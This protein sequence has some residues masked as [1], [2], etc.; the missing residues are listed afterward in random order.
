VSLTAALIVALGVGYGFYYKTSST[1]DIHSSDIK[2]IKADVVSIKN[3]MAN[4]A[5]F[6]GMSEVERVNLQDRV[7][8]IEDKQDKIL[9]LLNTIKMNTNK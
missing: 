9:D 7:S 4:I 8:R 2:E 5:I 6:K 1:L 3:D